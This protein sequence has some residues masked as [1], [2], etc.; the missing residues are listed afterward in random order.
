[1]FRD[2]GS[3]HSMTGY[4]LYTAQLS[5]TT[6]ADLGIAGSDPKFIGNNRFKKNKSFKN[7]LHM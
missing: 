5:G 7:V 2:Y 1:M 4:I 3:D 6:M